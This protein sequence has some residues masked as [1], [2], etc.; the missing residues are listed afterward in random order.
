MKSFTC[1]SS[2]LSSGEQTGIAIG[3]ILVIAAG[4]G[5]ALSM[6]RTRTTPSH[7]SVA[8]EKALREK[9]TSDGPD[10]DV[11]KQPSRH[12]KKSRG[13]KSG[14]APTVVKQAA[15]AENAVTASTISLADGTPVTVVTEGTGDKFTAL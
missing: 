14:K 8:D 6:T 10:G 15:G 3:S 1:S 5:A 4:I 12:S 13:S 2:G 7:D 11:K 9:G